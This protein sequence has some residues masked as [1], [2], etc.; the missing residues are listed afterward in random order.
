MQAKDA[1]PLQK[2]LAN[3]VGNYQLLEDEA[4]PGALQNVVELAPFLKVRAGATCEADQTASGRDRTTVTINYARVE[5][6]NARQAVHPLLQGMC[7]YSL[8]CY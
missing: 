4:G 3:K 2:L 7:T 5:I 6:F 8:R 1:N